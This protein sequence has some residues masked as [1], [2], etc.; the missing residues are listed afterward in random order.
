MDEGNPM[1]HVRAVSMMVLVTLLWSTAGVV[2]RQFEVAQGFEVTFWRSAFTV[3]ALSVALT[4][5]RGVA[6]WRGLWCSPRAVWLSGLCWAV[7]FTAFMLALTMTRVANV[8]VTMAIG[9]LVTA[10]FARLFLHHRLP[11][12]TW[13]A[14]AVAGAGIA[15]MFG[16]EVQ[17]ADAR[18][19]LGMAV[20]LA[21][22]LAAAVNFTVLQHISHGEVAGES[23]DMLPAVLIGALLSSLVTLPLAWPLQAS[24]HDLV[25][26]AGLG[27]F[28]LALPCLM[29][30]G[31]TRILPAPEI[32]LLGLLE[33]VFG[34]LWA[35][36]GAG[37]APGPTALT[38][39]ALVL[40]AL[41]GNEL[42]GWHRGGQ[43]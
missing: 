40:G 16:H 11:A 39:G 43:G 19:L 23:Q 18:S 12:R 37:E 22:P 1:S 30:V 35:W 20:A 28:Q 4:G 6:L 34:V 29:V 14:I 36:I 10:L 33:V 27:V 7:M 13:A 17:A 9:P 8:L 42:L 2:S 3:L 5:L 21:V 31:L 38:G 41:V 15:W 26:L 24:V 25:L 32:A